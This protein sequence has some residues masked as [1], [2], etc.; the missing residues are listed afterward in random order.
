MKL[1]VVEILKHLPKTNCKE[2]GEPTCMVF[3]AKLLKKE[4][5]LE[6]CAPLFTAEYE[7]RRGNLMEL[8]AGVAA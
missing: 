3:A 2:C 5:S 4:A 1:N 6:A 8:M 7:S